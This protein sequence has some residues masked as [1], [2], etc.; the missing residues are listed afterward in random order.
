MAAL[1]LPLR[2]RSAEAVSGQEAGNYD[3]GVAD[4]FVAP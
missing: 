1:E 3:G 2:H 4:S